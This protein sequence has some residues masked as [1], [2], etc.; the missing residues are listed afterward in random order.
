M[1][2]SK[3]LLYACCAP[4][5]SVVLERLSPDYEIDV[6]FCNPNIQPL[7][8]YQKRLDQ[9]EK[10]RKKF[11]FKII[12]FNENFPEWQELTSQFA[13]DAEGGARCRICYKYRLEKVA[14][15]GAEK[16]YEYF[17]T[18]LTVSPHKDHNVINLIGQKMGQKYK[19]SYLSSNFKKNNGFQR[20]LEL[21]RDLSL[22][23]QN[24]CGCLYAQKLR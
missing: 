17:A 5:A 18:T 23:R 1:P 20:S 9:F 19:M 2:C 10:L 16:K 6:I 14:Q 11:E 4:C 7:A 15:Y 22:Y 8:E 24:Y 13:K 21:S 3:L 12:T